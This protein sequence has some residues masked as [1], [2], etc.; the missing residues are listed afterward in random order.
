ME[1]HV[2]RRRR[3]LKGRVARA[4]W[5]LFRF[6]ECFPCNVFG[7]RWQEIPQSQLTPRERASGKMRFHCA[8]AGCTMRS[9]FTN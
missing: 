1:K 4:T 8:R 2:E 6:A 7:H 5:P 3:D 9:G